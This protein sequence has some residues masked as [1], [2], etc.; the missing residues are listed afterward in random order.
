MK[1]SEILKRTGCLASNIKD[2]PEITGIS[3]DS[4]KTLP[5]DLFVAI[6]GFNSD[7]ME[8]IPKALK[9]GASAVICDREPEDNIPY[10]LVKDCREALALASCAFFGEPSK[11]M[12]MIGVTGTNGK[13]TTTYLVKHMLETLVPSKI[14]LIGTNGIMIGQEYI[15]SDYTTPESFEL[16]KLFREMADKG[17]TYCV[18]EVSSHSLALSRVAGIHYD[19]AMFTNLTQD[20]LDFHKTMEEYAS[21]KKSL[22]S[23]CD[24]ACTNLDDARGLYMVEGSPARLITISAEGREADLR[25]ENIELSASG[26]TFDA[27]YGDESARAHLAIPGLFSVHNA[28]GVISIGLA[29]GFS[30]KDCCESL[31]T[32][33]GVKGRM[34]VVPTDGDYSVII[35]YSH[36]P[37]SLKNALETLKPLTRGTLYALFGCGGDRDKLKRPIMGEVAA[38]YAD[39]CIVTTD[40]PR[41]E[42]PEEIIKE[43]LEGVENA[44]TPYVS[45]CDRPSAIRWAIDKA[46]PGDVILLAGKGH[47]DYQVVGKT[48]HHMDEREI[49][50]GYLSERK[51]K[52]SSQ[53]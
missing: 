36:T 9:A 13:T 29:L 31:S 43:I 44:G 38:K 25:A 24:I 12:K 7:G 8:F 46:G 41:T 49:V 3:Y 17:C 27:V 48:K 11:E 18:M 40:N 22:F 23:R 19:V 21:V 16:Q 14:G 10:V 47:E 51:Q 50:A 39:F 26:V 30:L 5:G 2:D 45:I 4:R 1:L 34:E 35:D 52:G 53:C 32:A 15:H 37:D 20:H 42:D 33:T 28:L 6:R